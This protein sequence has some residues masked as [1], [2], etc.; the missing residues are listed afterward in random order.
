RGHAAI[1]RARR[2]LDAGVGVLLVVVAD[3]QTIVIA[4][5]RAG[6]RSQ[7]DVGGAAVAGFA[8]NVREGALVFAFANHRFVGR[9]DTCGE[10]AGAA[11][12]R[13]RP[14]H[15][16]GRTEIGA[17]GDIHT[18]CGADENGV[19]AGGLAGHAVLNRRPAAGASA[20]AGNEWFGR[21]EVRIIETRPL[22]RV[23]ENRKC[24]ALN[25]NDWHID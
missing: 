21:G 10:T 12:L 2:S 16:V 3:D 13:V 5:E 11:D 18:S 14:G 1:G 22:I 19:V 24:L 7:A 4:I 20:V 23:V 9:G 25:F 6:N 17:I 15:V 8:N